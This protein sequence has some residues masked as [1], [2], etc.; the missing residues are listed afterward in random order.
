MKQTHSSVGSG[1]GGQGS[2]Q[3]PPAQAKVLPSVGGNTEKEAD[4]AS[5]VLLSSEWPAD[6]SKLYYQ[7]VSRW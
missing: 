3:S 7:D 6:S 2:F 4:L 5:F 1:S